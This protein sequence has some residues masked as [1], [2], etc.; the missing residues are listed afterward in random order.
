MSIQ[1]NEGPCFYGDIVTDESLY[2][3]EKERKNDYEEVAVYHSELDSYFKKK[4]E[5]KRQIKNKIILKR[6]K[7]VDE[8]L[9]NEVW[10]LFKKMGF[11]EMN[12]DRNFKIQAGSCPKQID[13]YTKDDYNVFIIFCTSQENLSTSNSLKEKIREISDLKNDI[14]ITDVIKKY[15]DK[16]F[17]ISFILVTKN[18]V[19]N[20]SDEE[21]A[22]TKGIFFWKDEDLESYNILVDQLGYAAKYQLYGLLFPEKEA[23]EVSDI[24]VPAMR[25]GKGD[26]KYYCFL[27]HPEKLFKIAYV[28]RREKSNPEEIKKAYQRMIN[29]QRI[30]KIGEFID[31]GNSFPNN[32]ILSFR[33]PPEFSFGKKL[34][35]KSKSNKK[36]KKE[37]KEIIYGTLKFPPYYGCAWI[38]DGQHRLYGYSKSE[39]ASDHTIPV[40]AFESL[41]VRDQANLFVD[42]NKEQVAVSPNLLWDLYPDIYEGSEDEKQKKLSTISLIAKKLNSDEDSP[43]KGVIQIPS[44]LTR[45]K[46]HLTLEN[47]C[48]AIQENKLI[49]RDEGILY[50][51][52]YEETIN[53]A[54]RVIETYFKEIAES[55]KADWE[56]GKK[57]L[58]KSNIGIRIFFILLKETLRRFKYLGQE[59]I[60][61][62]KDL[63][64]FRTSVKEL[65]TPL[66][67][68][69]IKM[70]DEEKK[71]IRGSSSLKAVMN[72]AQQMA[73]W[74]KEEFEDFGL[75]ILRNWA[76]QR[77]KEV[78]DD[79]I[80]NL[81]ED[82]EKNLRQLIIEKLKE[83][84]GEKWWKQGVPEGVRKNIDEK[85]KDESEGESQLRKQELLSLSPERKLLGYSD[86]PHLREIIKFTPNWE[87]FQNIFIKD[88]EY[89][90]AQFKSFEK[91]RN[92]YQHFTEHELYDDEK[93]LG[94]WGMKW[95]RRYVGLDTPKKI[96]PSS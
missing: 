27:I 46:P 86:T 94:F 32:I 29:K 39:H 73:W 65:F 48:K 40:I 88:E 23:S 75:A 79:D 26:N 70:S 20:G 18:I 16:K 47:I 45:G 42:I 80:R 87:F 67:K 61:K 78:T 93:N 82:T 58:V 25:G 17:R 24:T 6:K 43:F 54:S 69:I 4:W 76:P 55:F 51:E 5:I 90:L 11:K 35:K 56:Q 50:E 28:H 53:L 52:N 37:E 59:N 12:K 10:L 83:R 81:L 22:T 30:E 64:E 9:E 49:E 2:E 19:W 41:K 7:E 74:I 31:K 34:K 84:Y 3:I 92:K 91:V 14:E 72:N 89:T 15:Y 60:Y 13:V 77:P 38:I 96:L 21:L 66:V 36:S 95:I 44:I 1:R 33:R 85:I 57:G 8:L 71:R 68:K 62:K 63:N